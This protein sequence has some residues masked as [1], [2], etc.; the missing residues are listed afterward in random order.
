MQE[1]KNSS[2][3]STAFSPDGKRVAAGIIAGI[4]S[5]LTGNVR[6]FDALTGMLQVELTGH[7]LGVVSVAFSPDG[8]RMVTGS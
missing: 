1:L 7:E 5:N 8:M 3:Y 4:G 6:I 2:A